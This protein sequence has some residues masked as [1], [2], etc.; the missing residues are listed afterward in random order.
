M[1]GLFTPTP[2]QRQIDEINTLRTKASIYLYAHND[3]IGEFSDIEDQLLEEN[4]ND[5]QRRQLLIQKAALETR[6]AEDQNLTDYRTT[7]AKI[8]ELEITCYGEPRTAVTI[9]GLLPRPH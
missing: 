9:P 2:R 1:S 6:I 3:L 4:L 8:H 5:D 7:L